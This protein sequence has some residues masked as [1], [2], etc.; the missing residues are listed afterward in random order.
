MYYVQG[1]KTVEYSNHNIKS[2]SM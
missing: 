2:I 1:K